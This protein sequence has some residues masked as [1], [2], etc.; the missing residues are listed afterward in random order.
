MPQ[1]TKNNKNNNFHTAKPIT[2]SSNVLLT[3]NV[4]YVLCFYRFYSA[5]WHNMIYLFSFST[6]CTPPFE[7]YV[8]TDALVDMATATAYSRGK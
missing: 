2:F 7:I 3:H 1:T 5:F 8:N 6:D 4:I